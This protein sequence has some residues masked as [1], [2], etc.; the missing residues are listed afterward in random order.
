MHESVKRLLE[1][2]RQVTQFDQ[3]P[4]IDFAGLGRRMGVSRQTLTNWKRRGVSKEGALQAEAAFGCS[5]QW[6]L[7]G[8]SDAHAST[9]QPLAGQALVIDEALRSLGP[10]A[11]HEVLEYIR[12]KIE[13]ATGPHISARRDRFLAALDKL[14]EAHE[15][16]TQREAPRARR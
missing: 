7:T 10:E 16:C 15:A 9:A 14:A 1:Y 6:I 8:E 2:A 11:R 5:A 4:V 3:Q 12:Y 13:R